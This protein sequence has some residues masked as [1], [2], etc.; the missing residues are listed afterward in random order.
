MFSRM[1]KHITRV[2]FAVIVA[3]CAVAILVNPVMFWYSGLVYNNFDGWVMLGVGLSAIPVA[4][5]MLVAGIIF[6][7]W[8]VA[9]PVT[10]AVVILALVSDIA[11]IPF[12]L[13]YGISFTNISSLMSVS[14]LL[15]HGFIVLCSA[16]AYAIGAGI[17]IIFRKPRRSIAERG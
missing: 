11:F 14:G 7:K 5:I 17:G 3:L 16:A 2:Q 12:D 4:V 9:V 15:Y 13:M 8:E 10:L 1:F 6:P